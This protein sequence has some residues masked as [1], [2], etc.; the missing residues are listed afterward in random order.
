MDATRLA[1]PSRASTCPASLQPCASAAV[2]SFALA[3][4]ASSRP[5]RVPARLALRRFSLSLP[6]T[7]SPI[8]DTSYYNY[9]I[10]SSHHVF[11]F[12]FLSLI[13]SLFLF[14]F[15]VGPNPFPPFSLHHLVSLLS[16]R[17][18]HVPTIITRTLI[19]LLINLAKFGR[20]WCM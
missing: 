15:G 2:A 5:A 7:H 18:E 4:L 1:M 16:F 11:L 20:R 19:C 14:G 8:H 13:H 17:C 9:T 6:S 12:L 3:N 10:V